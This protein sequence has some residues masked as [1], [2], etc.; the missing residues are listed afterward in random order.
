MFFVESRS[1]EAV[2][3]TRNGSRQLRSSAELDNN[4]KDMSASTS[5][6]RLGLRRSTASLLLPVLLIASVAA[7]VCPGC[8]RITLPSQSAPS[9]HGVGH[10]AD[11]VCDKDGCSCCGFHIVAAPLAPNPALTRLAL[12][13]TFSVLLFPTDSVFTLYRPPRC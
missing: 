3:R 9:F 2:R 10:E 13:P 6:L 8:S 7:L 1:R 5:I 11:S 4:V 12:A